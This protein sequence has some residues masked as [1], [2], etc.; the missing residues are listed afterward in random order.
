[1]R[2]IKLTMQ[3]FGPYASETTIDF[4]KMTESGLYLICGDTGAGKTML[5]D[6]ITYALYGE[7]SGSSRESG[8]LRSKFASANDVTFVKLEFEDRGERYTVYRELSREK[9]KKGVLC[10]EKSNEAWLT[11]PDGRTVTKH[12]DVTAAVSEIIGLDRERFRRTVMIA[13]GEFRELLYAKTDDRM[14]VL[15]KIF[16]TNLFADFSR[17]AKEMSLEEKKRVE[18]QRESAERYAS[19]VTTSD[20]ELKAVLDK[21]PFVEKREIESAFE[22]YFSSSAER[23]EKLEGE[24][25]KTTAELNI[26][27]FC[28][29]KAENDKKSEEKFL[30][31]KN[32]LKIAE[33]KLESVASEYEM[34]K[35]SLARVPEMR[36]N[37]ASLRAS[38][39]DYLEMDEVK[40]SL[41]DSSQ[42]LNTVR[43]KTERTQQNIE[44]LAREIDRLEK[45]N[46]ILGESVSKMSEHDALIASLGREKDEIIHWLE[47]VREYTKTKQILR[48]KEDE[49][50]SVSAELARMRATHSEMTS[51]YLDGIAGI[52]SSELKDN[53]PCPVCGSTTHPRPASRD[54]VGVDRETIEKLRGAVDSLSSAA[55]KVAGELGGIRSNEARLHEEILGYVSGSEDISSAEK[56]LS[57]KKNEV[58]SKLIEA[59]FKAETIRKNAEILEGNIEKKKKHTAVLESEKESLD[60]STL[61][62]ADI[63]AVVREKVARYEEVRSKLVFSGIDALEAEISRI[64]SE[65]NEIERAASEAE[66]RRSEALIDVEVLKSSVRTLSEQL[67]GSS[68]DRYDEYK[69]LEEKLSDLLE[70]EGDEIAKE[71]AEN[72]R[73][74]AAAKFILDT[75]SEICESEERLKVLSAISDTANGTVKGKEKIMLETFWQM[76]LFERIVRRANVRLMKMSDGRYELVRR[77][78]AENQREKSGLELDIVDHWNG[79]ERNV[80]TLSGGES[81][82]ASLALALALSDETE[83][84]SGG[85]RI[86]AMFIDEG[87]G[88]L[89]EDSLD[90][91]LEVLRSQSGYGRSVGIISHVAGLREKIE[92][93][94]I[95]TKTSG[96]SRITCV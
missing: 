10:E 2:P 23:I 85:V 93:K 88:S 25:K 94:I 89:D 41:D 20:D 71:A 64:E 60:K 84:E 28:L 19:L 24:K 48:E 62:I 12:K 78:T 87:F 47:M 45:E 61:T 46:V 77:K 82:A 32:S 3:A 81:F 18:T 74:R 34:A 83:A 33:E 49:Y 30:K 67:S 55:E 58:T 96:E 56:I 69:A 15:R 72:E 22:R 1:M 29:A 21:V 6:A 13:Q 5:F 16:K 38:A 8:M 63:S 90:T 75:L 92:H 51:R 79:R 54:T 65:A 53:E 70:K 95:I 35:K 66:G 11:Y 73:N 9:M 68:A 27:R 80:R 57:E 39:A 37:S 91:A 26:A 7:P 52:L 40:K 59:E 43:E 86:D 31:E 44:S 50:R 14:L 42:K 17:R 36:K 76:R 4:E